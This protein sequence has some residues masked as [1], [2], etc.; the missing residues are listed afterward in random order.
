MT[1]TDE[2]QQLLRKLFAAVDGRDLERFGSYLTDDAVFRFG[3]APPVQ[4][5]SA[6]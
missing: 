1:V 2:Q 4:G 5:R 6:I 3:S